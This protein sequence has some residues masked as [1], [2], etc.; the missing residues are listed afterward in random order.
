MTGAPWNHRPYSLEDWMEGSDYPFAFP[1]P[2]PRPSPWPLIRRI[3]GWLFVGLCFGGA[4]YELYF[5]R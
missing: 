2:Q 4:V 3:A 5:W 1:Q